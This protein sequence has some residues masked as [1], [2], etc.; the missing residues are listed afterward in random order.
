MTVLSPEERDRFL[1]TL[2]HIRKSRG[3]LIETKAA[4]LASAVIDGRSV[5]VEYRSARTFAEIRARIAMLEAGAVQLLDGR[6]L[7][8]RS[9]GR[10]STR[11]YVELRVRAALL[12]A[13]A[14]E[15]P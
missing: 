13:G 6:S 1:S 12:A 7:E 11:T 5:G 2:P 8:Y 15:L 14:V 9:V 10:A 4:P 3:L